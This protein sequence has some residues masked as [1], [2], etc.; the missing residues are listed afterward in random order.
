MNV[1]NISNLT[2][3]IF[4]INSENYYKKNNKEIDNLLNLEGLI[5][6]EEK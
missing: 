1:K 4:E 5:A 3:K 2:V 6:S